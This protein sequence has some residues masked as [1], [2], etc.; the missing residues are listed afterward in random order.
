V[1]PIQI[2][3]RKPSPATL[4]RSY[5]PQLSGFPKILNARRQREARAAFNQRFGSGKKMRWTR[6]ALP[7][8]SSF[9]LP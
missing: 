8:D 3:L 6:T 4:L 1:S 5:A 2:G 7:A 9:A